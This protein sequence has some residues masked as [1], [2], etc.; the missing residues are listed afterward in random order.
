[1]CHPKNST[2]ENTNY[3]KKTIARSSYPHQCLG[4]ILPENV[5]SPPA[6]APPLAYVRS[7]AADYIDLAQTYYI[8]QL[9]KRAS[10]RFAYFAYILKDPWGQEMN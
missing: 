4:T 9:P 10:A 8:L 1:M 5:A 6:P 7:H 3:T 2:D